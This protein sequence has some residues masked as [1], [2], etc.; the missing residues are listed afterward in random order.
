MKTIEN[1]VLSISL[2]DS[3]KTLNENNGSSGTYSY[4]NADE[5]ATVLAMIR[6]V[7]GLTSKE[8]AESVASDYEGAKN[9]DNGDGLYK[10]TT[11]ADGNEV[12]N[13]VGV[14]GG[15]CVLVTIAGSDPDLPSVT[16]SLIIKLQL[17]PN[18]KTL[19]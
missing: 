16:A 7:S 6:P 3:W 10:F 2:P 12:R 5:T 8:F 14:I 1:D 4:S 15:N 17:R 9:E 19:F 13:L 11:V 18:I